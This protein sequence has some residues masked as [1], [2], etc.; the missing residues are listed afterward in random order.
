[1]NRL[2]NSPGLPHRLQRAIDVRDCLIQTGDAAIDR[3]IG[4]VGE[5]FE[6]IFC[7]DGE[8]KIEIDGVTDF[9]GEGAAA[10]LGA[11]GQAGFLFWVE[12]D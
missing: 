7:F 6:V 8:F 4:F 9:L 2:P 11:T 3:L 5:Q 10:Q 12:M 1:M